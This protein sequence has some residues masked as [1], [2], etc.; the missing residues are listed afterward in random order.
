MLLVGGLAMI[1]EVSVRQMGGSVGTTLPKEM[2]EHLQLEPGDRLF[3]IETA[4]GILL[5]PYDPEFA[6]AF[7]AYRRGAK[8]YRNALAELA[9]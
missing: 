7:A 4:D 1:K 8:R 3:A 2:A 9:R 6:S 5:T